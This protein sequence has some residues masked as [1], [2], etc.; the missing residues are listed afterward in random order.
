MSKI[1]VFLLEETFGIIPKSCELNDFANFNYSKTMK[2]LYL[3]DFPNAWKN[4]NIR[5]KLVVIGANDYFNKWTSTEFLPLK[6]NIFGDIFELLDRKLLYGSMIN[7][8]ITGIP[9]MGGNHQLLFY[10]KDYVKEVPNTMMELISMLEYLKKKF[11]LKYPFVFPTG[12][13]YFILPFLYGYGADLW[14]NDN[15]CISRDSLYKTISFLR[16]LIYEKK[17]LPVKWE[18]LESK[19]C[20]MNEKAAFCIGGDWNIIEFRKRLS[21]KLGISKIPSLER[22][23]RS[24]ANAS[25]LFIS[26]FF[27]NEFYSI[28]K[29]FC[30]TFLS[31]EIQTD[32]INK[33][34]RMPVLNEYEVNCC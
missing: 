14:S 27:K 12:S 3:T 16:G 15:T 32:I 17:I 25:Y 11:D 29:R 33:L 8:D 13:C 28:I 9:L 7:G 23:C 4:E 18:Q 1:E 31:Q 10:N 5:N 6:K 26:N 19:E 34:Y 30:R 20:F 2:S 22:Q 24:T 21:R